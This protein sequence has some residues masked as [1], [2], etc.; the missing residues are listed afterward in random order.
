MI[1][2]TNSDPTET[3]RRYAILHIDKFNRIYIECI[4]ITKSTYRI[5][6]DRLNSSYR[7]IFADNT[8]YK[9]KI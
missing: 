2:E 7:V 5:S 1:V 8:F 9:K 3:K 4:P 6:E